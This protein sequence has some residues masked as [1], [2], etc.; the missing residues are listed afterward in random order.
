MTE[1]A[2]AS[3]LVNA[4]VVDVV[5]G[6]VHLGRNVEIVD[7]VIR[8][9]S[10]TLPPAQM[11]VT[12]AEGRFLLPGLISCTR[13]CLSCSPCPPRILGKPGGHG[14]TGGQ[15]GRR[16]TGGRDNHRPVCP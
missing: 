2:Q 14:I 1:T 16:C 9:I 6:E 5:D 13:T 11:G 7:G 15:A 4:K 12:D 10:S 8:S 3:W